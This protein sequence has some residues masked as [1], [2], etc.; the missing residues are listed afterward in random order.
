LFGNSEGLEI[1]HPFLTTVECLELILQSG[2]ECPTAIHIAYGFNYDASM[3][4][5]DLRWR[6]LNALKHYGV[7][8]WN[9]YEIQ[10][11]PNKWFKVRKDGVS[12]QIFDICSFWQTGYVNALIAMKVGSGEE[13]AHLKSE[14]ARRGQF[15]YS[16]IDDIRRYWRVEL[17]LG[18]ML[19]GSLRNTFL[20]SGFDIR[21]WHGPGALAN[22]AM[23]RHHVFDAMAITPVDVR[24]AARY[25]FAGGRFEMFR[26]G[27]IR[28]KIYNGDIN[29][30]YPHYARRLPNLANGNWRRTTDYEVDKFAVYRIRYRHRPNGSE[31]L[32]PYPL[33]RRESGGIV[34]WPYDTEGWYWQPEA[35]LVKDDPD[36]QF[37]EGWV[38]DEDDSSDRPFEWLDE[39]YRRRQMLK[40]NGNA[41]ELTF[42]LIINSIYGRLAQRTGYDRKR[43]EAPRT[44]QLEWAGFITSACRAAVYRAAVQCGD[45]LVSIDTDGIYA[46][47]PVEGIELGERLGEWSIDEYDEGIFWQSGI[48]TLRKEGEWIKGKSRGIRKG[49][50]TPEDLIR[51][52]QDDIPLKLTRNTFVGYGLAL[53]GQRDKLNTWIKEPYEVVFGGQGK[54][55]HNVPQWCAKGKCPGDGVHSFIAYPGARRPGDG[56][57]SQPH[58]LPWIGADPLAETT[59][60]LV[61]DY[62]MYNTNDLE[63]ED[64]WVNDYI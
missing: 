8:I 22:A 4:C 12:V 43:R 3:I 39:Y 48:Y 45:K 14:K 62:V 46:L 52:I 2:E 60:R 21:S 32:R 35:A 28:D 25:A 37:L 13:I 1:C 19:A 55:Y 50:Y 23:K 24:R 20:D 53:N 29:S 63:D 7:T 61:G 11:V 5:K 64:G 40:R 16:E 41:L 47:C 10:H 6:N 51:A 26:G 42:K 18:P 44:H 38:F 49:S 56:V 36:A 59:K 30:A 57:D 58:F 15:L 33:F 27:Y 9:G 17:R 34:S 31:G 54:R